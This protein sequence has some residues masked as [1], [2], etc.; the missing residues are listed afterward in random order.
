MLRLR[1]DRDELLAAVKACA[2]VASKGKGAHPVYESF[3]LAA[4]PGQSLVFRAT[5]L[6]T[7]VIV[8]G[9][10][11]VEES[12]L[13]VLPAFATAA[14]VGK[15]PAGELTL[16]CDQETC[17]ATITARRGVFHI[18]GQRP[19][20]FPEIVAEKNGV[21]I[22]VP[23]AELLRLIRSTSYAVAHER[24]RYALNGLLVK[25]GTGLVEFVA[26]DGRRL[27]YATAK[28]SEKTE[29]TAI[30]PLNAL[31]QFERMAR[32]A[33]GVLGATIRISTSTNHVFAKTAGSA[34][35]SR[36]IEGTFPNYADV[37]PR[38]TKTSAT[39]DRA[40]MIEVIG[41]AEVAGAKRIENAMHTS[42]RVDVGRGEIRVQAQGQV[43]AADEVIECEVS[44]PAAT[45][46]LNAEYLRH[47]LEAVAGEKVTL[48]VTDGRRP[49]K[50]VEGESIHVLMPITLD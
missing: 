32:E 4:M 29:L 13:A 7:G 19:A 30:A 2:S 48:E 49:V 28:I 40:E 41:R 34:I 47:M 20:D 10:G 21:S 26:T 25:A 1:I 22:D 50:V 16:T 42:V 33:A 38:T 17:E 5:D 12:G 23:A 46:G 43:G 27:A 24:M 11:L 8:E 37:I 31:R 3:H 14:L 39:F 36:V 15:L 35:V 18:A 44:G 6:E 9:N 45:V